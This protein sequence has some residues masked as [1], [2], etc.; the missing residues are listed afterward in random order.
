M[1]IAGESLSGTRAGM[2]AGMPKKLRPGFGPHNS[3]H[4]RTQPDSARRNSA[5]LCRTS[6][7]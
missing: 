5:M 3:S 4:I 2:D 1:S 7:N 6:P